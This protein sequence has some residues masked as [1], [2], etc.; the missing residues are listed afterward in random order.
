MADQEIVSETTVVVV[1]IAEQREDK[2]AR[3]RMNKK[4]K[5]RA[6]AEL[7][8]GHNA[9]LNIYDVPRK[10]LIF[11]VN[12]VLLFRQPKSPRYQVRPYAHEFIKGMSE[13]Y[14]IGVWTS[15][16][17]RFAVPILAE[18]FPPGGPQLKFQWYQNRCRAI[19]G[20]NVDDKPIFLKELHRVW[21]EHRM[22]NDSNTVSPRLHLSSS[23]S[24]NI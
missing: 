8:H 23:S 18:L 19:H 9:N 2:P 11:D 4:A 20:D 15:M 5:L 13:R 10:L 12:K 16:T 1:H 21:G 17:K 6:I 3:V 14:T 24:H 22:F 7:R